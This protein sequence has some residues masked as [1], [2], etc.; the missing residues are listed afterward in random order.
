MDLMRP[1]LRTDKQAQARLSPC[2]DLIGMT[3]LGRDKTRLVVFVLTEISTDF[4]K[5]RT[6]LESF[7]APLN[8]YSTIW[9][10]KL[11]LKSRQ[12]NQNMRRV[13]NSQY[14]AR[15]C[16]FTTK[17]CLICCKIVTKI[18]P[19]TLE[20][21][22]MRA[23][24]WKAKVSMQFRMPQNVSLCSNGVKLVEL[25]DKPRQISIRLDRTPFSKF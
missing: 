16:K 2:L 18:G 7:H 13:L 20:K 3:I 19:L 24:L 8:K 23:F 15:F 14:T 5:K 4:S 11:R 6:C 17:S 21:T 22:N 12:V 9:N 10:R 1:F 25:R